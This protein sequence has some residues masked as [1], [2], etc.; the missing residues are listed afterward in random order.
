[1]KT[2]KSLQYRL[3]ASFFL[4]AAIVLVALAGILYFAVNDRLDESYNS[5]QDAIKSRNA[6]AL[7]LVT[8]QYVN[9]GSWDNIFPVIVGIDIKFYGKRVVLVDEEFA[10]IADSK[11]EIEIGEIYSPNWKNEF[12]LPIIINNSD[13]YLKIGYLFIEGSGDTMDINMFYSFFF[14]ACALALSI[15][16]VFASVLSNRIISPISKLT[17]AVDCFASGKLDTRVSVNDD[18]EIA[19]L[20]D[21]FNIMASEIER[22]DKAS[23]SMLADIAHEL[24]TPLTNIG[25]YLE[26]IQDGIVSADE[27]TI[28]SIREEAD[29]LARLVSDLHQLSLAEVSALTMNMEETDVNVLLQRAYLAKQHEASSRGISVEYEQTELPKTL[30]DSQRIY[31]VISNL[32]NNAISHTEHGAVLIKATYDEKDIRVAVIDT[33][34]GI[35]EEELSS[36]FER[37]YRVDKSRSRK[38]GGTGLGLTIAKTLILAHKGHIGVESVRGVGSKF[39]F[40]LPIKAASKKRKKIEDLL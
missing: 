4:I 17:A 31:Q 35:P 5:A 36:I 20:A 24:R 15:V 19:R 25:G 6:M 30:A 14:I 9:D 22:S 16:I 26:A 33:G 37:F 3:I 32:L 13:E 27:K 12:D 8:Q 39:W 29:S 2:Y 23:K 18:S 7:D 10:L 38:S 34:E 11:S 28:K 40:S 21:S 1:M